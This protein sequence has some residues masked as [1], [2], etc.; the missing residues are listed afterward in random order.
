MNETFKNILNESILK[1]NLIF[2]S[3]FIALYESF[4]ESVIEKPKIWLCDDCMEES[5]W[6]QIESDEY[7]KLIKN[8]IVDDKGNKDIT[9]ASFLWFVDKYVFSAD[10]YTDFLAIKKKRNDIAHELLLLISEGFT[11]EDYKLFGKLINLYRKLDKWW[12]IN[13]EIELTCDDIP[14]DYDPEGV[15]GGQAIIYN[16]IIDIIYGNKGDEYKK[17]YED[18]RKNYEDKI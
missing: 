1:D 12:I 5:E 2:A 11:E 8:R 4:A 3:I 13:F 6:V 16:T 17:M 10:E 15:I 14:E 9:K 7:K 18:L